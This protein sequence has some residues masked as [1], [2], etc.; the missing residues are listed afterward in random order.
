MSVHVPRFHPDRQVGVPHLDGP[1]VAA[2]RLPARPAVRPSQP[3]DVQLA[4]LRRRRHARRASGQQLH[5][6]R[7]A[8]GRH[9]QRLP[10][11]ASRRAR[12]PRRALRGP[13][14]SSA[15]HVPRHPRVVSPARVAGRARRQSAGGRR[16]QELANCQVG[17]RRVQ[18]AAA[19]ARHQGAVERRAQTVQDA[20]HWRADYC[21]RPSDLLLT[22][23]E[24]LQ[25]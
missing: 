5:G 3:E 21:R 7:R 9:H 1:A 20:A 2:F 22:A 8:V 17:R 12:H 18:G 13:R 25:L 4:R 16:P 6:R 10:G 23:S 11:H 19:D 14:C 24:H 15:R